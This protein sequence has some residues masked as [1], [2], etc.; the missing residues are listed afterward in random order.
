MKNLFTWTLC[1]SYDYFNSANGELEAEIL[2]TLFRDIASGEHSWN[3]KIYSGMGKSSF[4]IMSTGNTEFVL[5]FI[6][7][8]IIFHLNNCK[9]NF[10]HPCILN[11]KHIFLQLYHQITSFYK[12]TKI[13]QWDSYGCS[14]KINSGVW[15][16]T[17]WCKRDS[18]ELGIT[19][20]GRGPGPVRPGCASPASPRLFPEPLGPL[21]FTFSCLL[22]E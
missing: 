5:L 10:S 12:R 21:L 20:W 13:C 22:L 7:H 4:T 1:D 2:N 14:A 15:R 6:N 18:D 19:T 8:C 11:V 16:S 3:F 17:F 9:P